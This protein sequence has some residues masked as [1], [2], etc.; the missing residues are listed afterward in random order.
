MDAS[1]DTLADSITDTNTREGEK[2]G[3]THVFTCRRGID[4]VKRLRKG[5]V[6]L[7]QSLYTTRQ[8]GR[9]NV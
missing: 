9:E 3:D 2:K 4:T 6:I 5:E 8:I 1:D 7:L